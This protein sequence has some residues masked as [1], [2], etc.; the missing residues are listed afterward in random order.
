MYK[1]Q[2]STGWFNSGALLEGWLVGIGLGTWMV[3]EANFKAAPFVITIFGVTVPGYAAVYAL[4]ANVVVAAAFTLVV[5]IVS[6]PE[7]RDD[8][9][10][11]DY[12]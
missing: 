5:N 2:F 11:A 1:R 12:G 3:I 10:A 6:Q 8:T 4:I 7:R 9:V